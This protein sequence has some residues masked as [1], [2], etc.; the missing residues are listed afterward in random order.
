MFLPDLAC[1]YTKKFPCR[2]IPAQFFSSPR[3]TGRSVNAFCRTTTPHGHTPQR[4]V[5]VHNKRYSYNNFLP[6][7]NVIIQGRQPPAV[8]ALRSGCG[9]G[10]PPD[11]IPHST[12][13]AA[14]HGTWLTQTSGKECFMLHLTVFCHFRQ[15]KIYY[16]TKY[17]Y[18]Y[19]TI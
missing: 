16:F 4:T 11:K 8:P 5:T 17:D 18:F 1:K 6:C 10:D 3:R 7:R 9:T 12:T 19:K 14:P 2:T 15:T 13:S